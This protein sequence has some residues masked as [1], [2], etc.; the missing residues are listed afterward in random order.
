M[1]P[2]VVQ[3]LQAMAIGGLG[4]VVISVPYVAF[5]ILRLRRRRA[6]DTKLT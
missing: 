3:A 4:G 6:G 5:A 1:N 2:L